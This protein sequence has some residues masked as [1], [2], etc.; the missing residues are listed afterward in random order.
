MT[1]S[2]QIPINNEKKYLAIDTFG[3]ILSIAVSKKDK[4]HYTEIDANMKQSEL[5][6]DMIDT[7]LKN[8][9]IT[10]AE[11]DMVLC[12]KGPGS[13]TGLR[14]GYSIAKGLVLS[15]GIPFA[16]IPTL[17]CIAYQAVL[18]TENHVFSDSS[19]ILAVIES[20]KN[21]FY[22]TFFKY[23]SCENENP[24]RLTVDSDGD[25][26]Q[27]SGEIGNYSEKIIITGP[28]SSSLYNCLPFELKRNI[29]VN[30]YT[31]GYAKE[32]II[33]AIKGKI[34]NNDNN[35]M[36]YSGPEYIRKTPAEQ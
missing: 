16:S 31:G 27:I 8:T 33:L 24:L 23:S 25:F 21:S 7:Q 17:D 26:M 13:F 29:L 12:M 22:Y 20:G 3:Q 30:D 1:S 32:L 18:D 14:I 2:I 36:I 34:F 5:V 4:F 35:S 28:G 6:M 9:E 10:P 15:L 19:L 11:L